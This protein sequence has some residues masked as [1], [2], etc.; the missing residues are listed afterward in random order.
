MP[1]LID[2]RRFVHPGEAMTIMVADQPY[3]GRVVGVASDWLALEVAEHA[4][5]IGEHVS[6]AL[7]RDNCR[8]TTRLRVSH[9]ASGTVDTVRLELAAAV[10]LGERQRRVAPQRP[11]P[12]TVLAPHAAGATIAVRVRVI[13]VSPSGLAFE[14]EDRFRPGDALSL[15]P[16]D[17]RGSRWQVRVVRRRVL[18]HQR[19]VFGCRRDQVSRAE[20]GVW[21][22]P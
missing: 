19:A 10:V 11:L 18:D 8:L 4:V 22:R 20:G 7:Y 9:I 2:L 15:V 21:A 1:L 12:A 17:D 6:A 3:T 14:S 5:T 16:D 13:D